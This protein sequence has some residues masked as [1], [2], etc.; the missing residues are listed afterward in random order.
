M[1]GPS[2]EHYIKVA[3]MRYS[4]FKVLRNQIPGSTEYKIPIICQ[5]ELYNRIENLDTATRLII[6]E[7]RSEGYDEMTLFYQEVCQALGFNPF[8]LK[9]KFYINTSGISYANGMEVELINAF[10]GEYEEW[11]S[12]QA[13]FYPMEAINDNLLGYTYFAS[14][15][16]TSQASLGQT[17][18]GSGGDYSAAFINMIRPKQHDSYTGIEYLFE[19]WPE[20]AIDNA[21][22][23]TQHF[24]RDEGLIKVAHISIEVWF[25]TDTQ[26]FHY[27]IYLGCGYYTQGYT[28]YVD[29]KLNQAELDKVYNPDNPF[30]NR[31]K[32]GDDGG[33]QESDDDS[34]PVDVPEL[35]SLDVSDLGGFNLYRVYAADVKTLYNYLNSHDPGESI[36]KWATNPIQ[37]II[38]LHVLPYPVE[39]QPGQSAAISVLGTPT[40]AAGYKIKPYQEWELGGVRVPYGFDNT[41]LDYEP[42]TRVSIYLPF[43]G[44]RPLDADEVM[45]Q[46][47][48]VTYQFDNISGACIAFVTVND[49]VRYSFAGSCAMSLP[50][51][52]QNWGQTY[53]A[54]AT[55]AAGA[56]S[57]GIGAAAGAFGQ[58]AGA[59]AG[60]GLIGAVQGA[61]KAGG[62]LN[63]PKPSISRSGTISGAASALG[64]NHPY[65][66]IERPVKAAAANPAPVT[67]LVSG[68]TLSLGSL[69]GYNIIE[70]VHLSGV[71]AT[72]S[73]LDEIEKLLYQ[74][75]VF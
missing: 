51:S 46:A 62:A 58:G 60:E 53:I 14:G 49:S 70:S 55:V 45:G 20:T 19:I 3:N 6:L 5:Q 17:V 34:D 65:L 11:N 9:K 26:K 48:E 31:Q 44:I 36:M 68:R 43:I 56:F 12:N 41:F 33:D 25:N 61:E 32:D 52:Q 63:I 23:D 37:G 18:Y 30:D 27:T 71:P 7:G 38:S 24:Y 16:S 39:L 4:L 74:G 40:G 75:V 72:A 73:E 8:M 59:M 2:I 66:I 67:G 35:P 28:Q 15:Y 57:G 47:V 13:N 50:I 69:S 1:S 10:S 22:I 54:A 64:V 42:Y 21:Y 29:T